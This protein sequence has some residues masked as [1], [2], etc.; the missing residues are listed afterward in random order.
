MQRGAVPCIRAKTE[1]SVPCTLGQASLRL[2]LLSQPVVG[3][4][5]YGG[6]VLH[7]KQGTKAASCYPSHLPH[8]L[9]AVGVAARVG[10]GQHPSCL[11]AYA[12]RLL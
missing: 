8:P 2:L 4:G 12:H 3:V 1:T 7:V 10:R 5:P 6:I 11:S 9:A